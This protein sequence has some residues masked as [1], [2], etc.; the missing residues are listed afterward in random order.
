MADKYQSSGTV[1]K[2]AVGA[3]ALAV[4]GSVQSV[5]GPAPETQYFDGS[6]LDSGGTVEDG[7]LTQTTTPGEASLS[8]FYDPLDAVHSLIPAQVVDVTDREYESIQITGPDGTSTISQSG[9]TKSFKPKASAKEAY[10]ADWSW[11]GRALP[12]YA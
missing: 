9:S 12:V 10:M 7:E 8:L 6:A 1:V 4:V 5:E 2:W 3:G 11:K